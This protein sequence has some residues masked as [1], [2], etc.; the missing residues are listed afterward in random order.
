MGKDFIRYISMCL[1]LHVPREKPLH[2][3]FY[4][5]LPRSSTVFIL[6]VWKH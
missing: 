4:F 5:A 6:H 1:I 3:I 2:N